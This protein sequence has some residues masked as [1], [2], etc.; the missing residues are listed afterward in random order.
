M[1]KYVLLGTYDGS[2]RM[3]VEVIASSDNINELADIRDSI[4]SVNEKLAG[5]DRDIPYLEVNAIIEDHLATI[6]IVDEATGY[7]N[8]IST[9]GIFEL[10]KISSKIVKKCATCGKVLFKG[11]E[12]EA[13]K[14]IIYC[15]ECWRIKGFS[16]NS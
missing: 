6:N 11:T 4:N 10:T 1:E 8:E 9:I 16:L 5:K 15:D 12:Q 14:L 2:D 13:K 3:N 7:L